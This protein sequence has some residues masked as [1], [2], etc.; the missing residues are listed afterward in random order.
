LKDSTPTNEFKKFTDVVLVYLPYTW[1]YATPN[2][3]VLF[4]GTPARAKREQLTFFKL[5][6]R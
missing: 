6:F 2:T 5:L 4:S 1:L 3:G